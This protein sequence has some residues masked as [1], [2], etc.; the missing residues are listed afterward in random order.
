MSLRLAWPGLLL[1]LLLLAAAGWAA[2]GTPFRGDQALFTEYAKRMH[3]GAVLY[4]DLWEV[5]NPGVFWFYQLAG[6][7]FGFTEDGVHLGEWLWWVGF[8]LVVGFAVKRAHGLSKWPLAPAVLVGGIY[9][10]TSCSDPSHLTKAEGLAAFPLFLTAWLACMAVEKPRPNG[11]L[12]LAAG[13]AGGWRYC[14]S[15]RLP[16]ACLLH[17]CRWPC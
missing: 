14:S 16:R 2:A 3:A 4:R 9:F 7:A 5:T 17:G 6:T 8:V 11:W 12:L 10:L 1:S 15:S 13:A